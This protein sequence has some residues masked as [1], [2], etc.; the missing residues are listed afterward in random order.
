MQVKKVQ[1]NVLLCAHLATN[2]LEI[3]YEERL[4]QRFSRHLRFLSALFEP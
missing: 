1:P 2:L 3:P 4:I